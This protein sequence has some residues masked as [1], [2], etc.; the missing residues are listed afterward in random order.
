MDPFYFWHKL[1]QDEVLAIMKAKTTVEDEKRK[2]SWEIARTV[3]FFNWIAFQGNKKVKKA[4]DLFKL[5]WD[6][7]RKP[8]PK[9]KTSLNEIKAIKKKFNG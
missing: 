8:E 2:R 1:S 7:A 3:C 9:K 6:E 5:S 4:E